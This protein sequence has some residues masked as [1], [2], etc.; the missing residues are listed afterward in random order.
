VPASDLPGQIAGA[1]LIVVARVE[2]VRA[3]AGSL[4]LVSP[5]A[6]PE[7]DELRQA[8]LRVLRVLAGAPPSDQPRLF[9]LAGRVPSRP[10]LTLAEGQTALLML[11]VAQ[12]GYVPVTPTGS[13]LPALADAAAPPPGTAPAQAVAREVEQI[14]LTGGPAVDEGLIERA[15]T[16]RLELPGPVELGRLDHLPPPVAP[17]RAAW[18]ALALAAGQEEALALVP[19][20]FDGPPSPALEALQGLAVQQ[21]DRDWPRSARPRLVALVWHERPLVARAAA[22]A[23]RRLGDPAAAADLIGALD[24]PD[25]LVRYDAVMGLAALEPTVDAGPSLETF[26]ADEARYIQTWKT[27][28]RQ[29]QR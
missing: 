26:R 12:A 27:W 23:L 7:Y 9:F 13:A 5:E 1:D 11:R 14:I 10:W 3:A 8:D 22:A 25:Q 6:R 24:H 18:I 17:R 19:T 16:A 15:A 4:A 21:I 2:R 29:R 20:L 28:W